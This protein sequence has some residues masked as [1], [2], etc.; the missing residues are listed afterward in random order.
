M[1]IKSKALEFWLL[2]C[3]T[4]TIIY[5]KIQCACPVHHMLVCNG[6]AQKEHVIKAVEWW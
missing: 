3:A 4:L 2:K 5:I 1:L 6:H